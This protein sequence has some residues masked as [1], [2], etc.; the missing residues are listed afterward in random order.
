MRVA[1]PRAR[2]LRA[3]LLGSCAFLCI[4]APATACDVAV[5]I[6][7]AFLPH[8]VAATATWVSSPR[9]VAPIGSLRTPM[10]FT[11]NGSFDDAAAQSG[12]HV[13]LGCILR[14][15]GEERLHLRRWCRY[16]RQLRRTTY[17]DSKTY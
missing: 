7:F 14:P 2:T 9:N 6:R 4:A 3:W 13:F 12:L 16:L 15:A 11:V 1:R 5:P 10:T 8:G 17:N